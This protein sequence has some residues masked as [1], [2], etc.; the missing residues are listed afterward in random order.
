[1]R[2]KKF[3]VLNGEKPYLC[4]IMDIRFPNRV[5][6]QKLYPYKVWKKAE[7]KYTYGWSPKKNEVD[8]VDNVFL[9]V[10]GNCWDE[11]VVAFAPCFEECEKNSELIQKGTSMTELN[12]FLSD[13]KNKILRIWE[14]KKMFTPYE[15]KECFQD[16]SVF[17]DTIGKLVTIENAYVLPDNDILLRLKCVE[18]EN[19]YYFWRKL[20]EIQIDECVTDMEEYEAN[21]ES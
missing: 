5:V 8:F 13:T 21:F 12:D 11:Y 3:D 20:S 6:I 4:L 18:M 15:E 19:D 17:V 7:N 1:M 14:Y 16:E 2:R 9:S 10:H